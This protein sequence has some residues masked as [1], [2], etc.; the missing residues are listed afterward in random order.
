MLS[1]LLQMIYL[2]ALVTAAMLG[3]MLWSTLFRLRRDRVKAERDLTR[4]KFAF[5][6]KERLRFL[7]GRS[8]KVSEDRPEWE[9]PLVST[10]AKIPPPDAERNERNLK[11]DSE[12]AQPPAEP[13]VTALN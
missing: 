5:R 13:N 1:R 8:F 10:L 11:K 3:F 12:Q 7:L 2:V 4:G 9:E 6:P